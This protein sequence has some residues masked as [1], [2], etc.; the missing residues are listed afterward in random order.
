MAD[1][2]Q[3]DESH[4]GQGVQ[5]GNRGTEDSQQRQGTERSEKSDDRD[6]GVNGE[7][8]SGNQPDPSQEHQRDQSKPRTPGGN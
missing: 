5:Q 3:N 8:Q 1:Q 4:A 6:R 2:D 7:R